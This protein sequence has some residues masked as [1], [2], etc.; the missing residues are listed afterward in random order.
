MKIKWFLYVFLAFLLILALFIGIDS[1]VGHYSKSAFPDV[2]VGVD[3][4]YDDVEN[5]ER[6]ID[7]VKVYTNFFVLGSTAIIYNT[8]RLNEVCQY[9][10]DSGLHFMIYMHPTMLYNQSQWIS[11]ARQKWSGLFLG[12][13]AHD[14]P[15]GYQIDR[16]RWNNTSYM[17]VNEADNY[18]DAA[19]KYNESLTMM[20]TEYRFDKFPLLTS[21]YA[22]YDFNYRGGYD[23]V[24]AEFGWN[25]SRPINVALCRGAAT[26]RNKDWGVMIT[27]TYDNAPYLESGPEMYEDMVSAYQNGAKYILVFERHPKNN[28]TQGIFQKEH[29]E[30][31]KQFWEYAKNNPK[32]S[33]SIS[34]RVAYVLPKDY[35][36]GFRGPKDTIWGLWEADSLSSTIWNDVNA[37]VDQYKT[38]LDIIYE[39]DLQLKI[40]EYPKLVFW[41]GT[42]II[43]SATT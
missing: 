32:T 31:L 36:Y 14:E 23:V 18:T 35:G 22:L 6:I 13:Y 5:V 24:L 2:L 39:D 38:R 3:V 8:T 15:G 21:D 12:L 10:N 28:T 9:L 40:T 41:N 17:L 27:W 20:L 43:D 37:L 26:V 16:T 33:R 1:Y 19:D 42:T 7:E 25:H 11:E 4:V 34:D 30:A 29:F